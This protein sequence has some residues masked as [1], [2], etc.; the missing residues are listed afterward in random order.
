VLTKQI[1]LFILTGLNLQLPLIQ[2]KSE[3]IRLANY[4]KEAG[5]EVELAVW[6]NMIHGFLDLDSSFPEVQKGRA[7]VIKY[8]QKQFKS[9]LNSHNNTFLF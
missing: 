1:I 4:A 8:M 2:K 7:Q 5:V 3:S 6:E 9:Q